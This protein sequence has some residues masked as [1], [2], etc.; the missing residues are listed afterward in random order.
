MENE[1]SPLKKYRRQPKIYI[2]LPSRG[3]YYGANVVN[4]SA[5]TEMPVFS[6]TANDEILFKTP[7]A[8]IN[9]QAT[10]QNI[11][12]CI[13]SILDPMNLV[14]LDIDHIL[15]G[16]RMATYGPSLAITSKCKHCDH[17][18]KYDIDIQKILDYFNTLEYSDTLHIENFV[19]KI[20][21]LTY[22]E[23]T[24]L[25]QRNTAL[26]RALRVQAPKIKDETERAEFQNRTLQQIATI[27]VEFIFAS[28]YSITVDGVEETNKLEIKEFLDDNDI[29]FYNQ[30]KKHIE[31]QVEKW[32]IPNQRVQCEECE[33]ENT[34]VVRVDQS[35]F[36]VKG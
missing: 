16:I 5:F 18:N 35:D 15:L 19:V 12:S 26:T 2:N 34:V 36:F 31:A 25:Q 29:T 24:E 1:L 21:P 10:A 33:K 30:I 17:E 13:P 7:D 8:L 6:M 9:G 22:R 28:I 14:T 4:N 27:A 20:R 3:K 11:R 23:Y 32:N